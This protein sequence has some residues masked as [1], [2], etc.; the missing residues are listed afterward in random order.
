MLVK[1]AVHFVSKCLFI[2]IY[3][4]CLLV[5]TLHYCT[6]N[7]YI[8]AFL[9]VG[10]IFIWQ[11]WSHH[12]WINQNAAEPLDC[13]TYRNCNKIIVCRVVLFLLWSWDVKHGAQVKCSIHQY[14]VF[15]VLWLLNVCY[16]YILRCLC[17]L[18]VSIA[19]HCLMVMLESKL[20]CFSWKAKW[21]DYMIWSI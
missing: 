7:L 21:G 9:L 16:V 8:S 4:L 6:C 1:I 5:F 11:Y 10:G 3:M 17:P 14:M 2:Q 18:L 13:L 12:P 19:F 15:K 20:Q